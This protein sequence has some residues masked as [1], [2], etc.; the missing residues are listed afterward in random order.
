[1]AIKIMIDGKY[2]I[3]SIIFT[4]HTIQVVA[5]YIDGAAYF[6]AGMRT[7]AR[8]TH[9]VTALHSRTDV[10]GIVQLFFIADK[11]VVPDLGAGS[12]H[13]VARL[14]YMPAQIVE[15]GFAFYALRG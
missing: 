8:K 12:I 7:A 11:L 13:I 1:M 10:D 15:T 9:S 2:R 3:L 6:N 5:L 14:Q 4:R